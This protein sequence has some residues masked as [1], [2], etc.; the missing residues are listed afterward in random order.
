MKNKRGHNSRCG[1]IPEN[2]KDI[3]K[4]CIPPYWKHLKEM[5]NFLD[6]YTYQHYQDQISNL[7]RLI[8][9]SEIETVIKILPTPKAW[10]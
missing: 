2:L 10:G 4:T 6:T 1:E 5:N 3:L 9:P 7:N 8:T